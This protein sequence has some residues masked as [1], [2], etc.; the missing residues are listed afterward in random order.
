MMPY[1][2]RE[3]EEGICMLDLVYPGASSGHRK[4]GELD[5]KILVVGQS[6]RTNIYIENPAFRVTRRLLKAYTKVG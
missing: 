6:V 5:M 3:K 1:F 2:L 4:I